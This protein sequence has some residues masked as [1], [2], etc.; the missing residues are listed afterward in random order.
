MLNEWSRRGWITAGGF[1]AAIPVMLGFTR[2]ALLLRQ[3]AGKTAPAAPGKALAFVRTFNTM[4]VVLYAEHHRFG[5]SDELVER[6]IESYTDSKKDPRDMEWTKFLQFKEEVLPG[7]KLDFAVNTSAPGTETPT[8]GYRI[9]LTGP[10]FAIVS[11]EEAIIYTTH[12][13]DQLPKAADLPA[14]R[15]APGAASI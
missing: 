14:A 4:Q 10:E 6:L 2:S 8:S 7:W 5:T 3:T 9:I 11:D 12:E 1:F 15:L 13:L